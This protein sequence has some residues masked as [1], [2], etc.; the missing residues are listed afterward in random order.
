MNLDEF[1]KFLNSFFHQPKEWVDG[2]FH[3]T[4]EAERFKKLFEGCEDLLI[5]AR[6]HKKPQI[7]VKKIV[8]CNSCNEKASLVDF[9]LAGGKLFP[10]CKTCKKELDSTGKWV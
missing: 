8:H 6:T 10:Y 2:A 9:N 1:E 3:V 5:F 7:E 4:I